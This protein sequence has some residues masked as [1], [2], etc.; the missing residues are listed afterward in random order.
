MVD[1]AKVCSS[2]RGSAKR[3]VLCCVSDCLFVPFVNGQN[4]AVGALAIGQI[5]KRSS[6]GAARLSILLQLIDSTSLASKRS[7]CEALK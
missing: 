2:R 1:D 7:G 4:R 5:A 6:E 3:F